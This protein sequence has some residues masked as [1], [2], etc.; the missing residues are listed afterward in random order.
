M[1]TGINITSSKE[2]EFEY[3][4][5]SP[6]GWLFLLVYIT[7]IFSYFLMNFKKK[8]EVSKINQN[9]NI[10]EYITIPYSNE[11]MPFRVSFYLDI[12]EV[13]DRFSLSGTD[14][15]GS[16][17]EICK[18]VSLDFISASLHG[19]DSESGKPIM[20]QNHHPFRCQ[21]DRS[22]TVDTKKYC[23]TLLPIK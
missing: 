4:W 20:E 22:S 10:G 21:I 15:E 8:G 2:R 13:N 14:F 18:R 11:T 17:K 5:T 19:W 1:N 23:F 6:L 16:E 12:D 9:K 3:R 7:I